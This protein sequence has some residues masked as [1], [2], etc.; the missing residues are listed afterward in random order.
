MPRISNH[1]PVTPQ[2]LEARLIDFGAE[3]C[4]VVRQMPRDS[5]GVQISRQ[6]VRSATSPAANY[7]EACAAES[8]R[9]F[10][11]KMRICL[12]ELRETWVWLRFSERLD[13]ENDTLSVLIDECNQLIS[14]FVKSVKT[15]KAAGSRHRPQSAT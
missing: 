15:A 4:R 6:L 2:A 13:G 3:V 1:D 12:K 9:D 10:I 11:H 8:R 14:I 7:A 5:V